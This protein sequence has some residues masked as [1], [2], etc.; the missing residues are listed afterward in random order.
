MGN[1][2]NTIAL[3]KRI[4]A[5]GT[6][7]FLFY[8]DRPLLALMPKYEDARGSSFQVP[9]SYSDPSGV[10]GAF[11]NAQT[12]KNASNVVQFTTTTVDLYALASIQGKD[13]E[14]SK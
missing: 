3:L 7:E 2:A 10:S 6:I 11:T 14:S 1:A 9:V 12:N 4:Y 5:P 8:Q 13:I